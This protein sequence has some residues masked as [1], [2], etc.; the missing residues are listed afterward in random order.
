[1]GEEV[2]ALIPT[3]NPNHPLRLL[4]ITSAHL[5]PST[6]RPT[7]GV[8]F[9][10]LLVRLRPLIE[11]LVVVVPTAYVPVWCQRILMLSATGPVIQHETWN[12]LEIHRPA[13]FSIRSRRHLWFQS[14]SASLAAAAIC[15]ALHRRYLFDVVL[16]TGFGPAAH[17]SQ[18]V[19]GRVGR[20]SVAWAIG[21]DVHTMPHLSDENMR[22]FRHNVRHSHLILATSEA[23]RR[24]IL[25]ICPWARH[26][27]TFYRGIELPVLR[28]AA[29]RPA[30][31]RDLGLAADRTYMLTAGDVA[32]TKGSEEFYG[33]FRQLAT[34]WP[35][36]AAVWVGD[37]A[38]AN[39]LRR[40]AAQ[41]G[42][43]DRFTITGQVPRA[44]VLEFMQ[45]ADVMAFPSH[46]EG[47]PNVVMEAMAAG[48]PVVAT[49]VGGIPE[50]I[51]GGVT[52]LRTPVKDIAG[53]A[54]GVERVLRDPVG[55]RRRAEAAQHL[56]RSHFDVGRNAPVLL[57]ILE[58]VA[59]GGATDDPLPPC[60]GVPPGRLPRDVIRTSGT[61]EQEAT[62]G[63]I[64]NI[65]P[66][67]R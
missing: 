66:D 25:K 51:I 63:D 23:L 10:N 53:M 4:A 33:C 13:Y 64:K 22:L 16:S 1:M 37:G 28:P 47:L 9:A 45:A 34:R 67:N 6:G 61:R 15:E 2:I 20:R 56:I 29:E 40:L 5:F 52:G 49:G 24:E 60:A 65:H 32:R 30:I 41:D 18:Y 59:A 31:R 57:S 62:T 14:R 54:A 38:E 26:A 7:A 44:R 8:F 36:L 12:G 43:T 21:S 11:N 50:I 58:G 48:L 27:H 19:A 42:L 3:K 55:A 39:A 17:V 46:A 35:A